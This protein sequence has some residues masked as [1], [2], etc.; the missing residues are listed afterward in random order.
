MLGA[1]G[2]SARGKGESLYCSTVKYHG[3]GGYW[4][5]RD[6][7]MQNAEVLVK[8]HRTTRLFDP[9]VDVMAELGTCY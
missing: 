1:E 6:S 8:G 5:T 9:K 2:K 4:T 3:K 7:F